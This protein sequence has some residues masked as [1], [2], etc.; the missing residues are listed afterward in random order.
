MEKVEKPLN[1]KEMRT[2]IY[3]LDEAGESTGYLVIGTEK[4]C[5]ID[6]K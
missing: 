4:A 1:I 3:L 6:T 2:G 5:L